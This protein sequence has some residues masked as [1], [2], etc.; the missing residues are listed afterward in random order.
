MSNQIFKTSPPIVILF[1]FLGDVCEK[2]KNKYVFSKS[3]FKKALIENKL[4]SFYDKLKPHYYQSKLFYI[5]RDM[6]YKNFITLIRQICKHH[7]IAFTSVM[8]YN[9][10]KYE[11]IYSIFIP[12]QLI[13]V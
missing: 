9:K 3:S 11:I 12:E 6:I 5:T 13:V 1:D 10:S 8:K 2:Q 4:E 7:H